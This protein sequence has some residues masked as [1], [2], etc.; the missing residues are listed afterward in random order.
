MVWR[1]HED[2][3]GRCPR[4][5]DLWADEEAF[6]NWN[7]ETFRVGDETHPEPGAVKTPWVIIVSSL[8]YSAATGHFTTR[9]HYIPHTND[10]LSRMEIN[11]SPLPQIPV[12]SVIS[13]VR[14]KLSMFF[15]CREKELLKEKRRRRQELFQEQ[16]VSVRAAVVVSQHHVVL[17]PLSSCDC[18]YSF[19]PLEGIPTLR[20]Q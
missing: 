13:C 1:S 10:D 18:L 14:G 2:H 8:G 3:V 12:S 11:T 7:E 4:P 17:V 5:W 20:Y 9:C 6:S 16:K 19:C 15:V